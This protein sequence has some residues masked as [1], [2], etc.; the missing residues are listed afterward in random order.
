M[1]FSNLHFGHGLFDLLIVTFQGQ[2][3]F[4]QVWESSQ[5]KFHLRSMGVLGETKGWPRYGQEEANG[6]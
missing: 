2:T 3:F 5:V 1:Q 4:D 6:T